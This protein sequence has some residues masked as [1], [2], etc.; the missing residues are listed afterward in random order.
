MEGESL[1]CSSAT[2]GR[3]FLVIASQ[4]HYICFR[5]E[6]HILC[7]IMEHSIRRVVWEMG[8]KKCRG[9][10]NLV[11]LLFMDLHP[12][13]FNLFFPQNIFLLST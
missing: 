1:S 11:W 9:H 13:M 2:L 6:S 7:D 3:R 4:S 12:S 5:S 10:L 8:R